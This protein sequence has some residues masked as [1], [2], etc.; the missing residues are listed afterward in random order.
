MSHSLG[1]V[2]K[3]CSNPCK[4]FSKVGIIIII[5]HRKKL[6]FFER[7]SNFPRNTK[8]WR[9]EEDSEPLLSSRPVLFCWPCNGEGVEEKAYKSKISLQ[10]LVQHS[11]RPKLQHLSSLPCRLHVSVPSI[12]MPATKPRLWWACQA[13]ALFPSH[14]P[15]WMWSV[16]SC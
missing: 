14:L 2:S 4:Q 10:G 16:Q 3:D 9:T 6:S 8:A 12:V 5:S 1:P 11:Q 15:L 7:W 13:V